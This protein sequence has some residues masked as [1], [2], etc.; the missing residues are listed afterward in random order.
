MRKGPPLT[1]LDVS[2]EPY[3]HFLDWISLGPMILLRI[4]PELGNRVFESHRA[5]M[6]EGHKMLVLGQLA[7]LNGNYQE[8]VRLLLSGIE[9]VRRNQFWSI[10]TVLLGSETLA[11]ALLYL[12]ET[13]QAAKVLEEASQHQLGTGLEGGILWLRVRTKLYEI[14]NL[15]GSRREAQQIRE[16]LLTYLAFADSD[17]TILAQLSD[18]DET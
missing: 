10:P 5:H 7:M 9:K 6:T 17:H 15:Q 16:Q 12:G 1:D 13:E 4:D 2:E 3:D 8:A 11:D 18:P 14:Y